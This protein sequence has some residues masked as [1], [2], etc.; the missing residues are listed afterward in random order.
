[1]YIKKCVY[2]FWGTVKRQ[3][4]KFTTI[5]KGSVIFFR[6]RALRIVKAF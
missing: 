4:K 1:M 5:L 3:L 6:F 2:G